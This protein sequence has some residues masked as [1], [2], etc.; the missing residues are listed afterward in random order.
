[1][2]ALKSV[3]ARSRRGIRGMRGSILLGYVLSPHFPLHRL[4]IVLLFQAALEA[5]GRLS[6]S[7][8]LALAT[9]D[10]ES[11]LGST[12]QA[13]DEGTMVV[14]V[15]GDLLDLEAKVVGVVDGARGVVDLF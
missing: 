15:G 6:K 5:G 12:V 8:A 14:T 9:T 7:D 10:L 11:L 13:Q 1:M 4:L 2:R 3:S